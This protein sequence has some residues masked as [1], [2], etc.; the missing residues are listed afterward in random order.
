MDPDDLAPCI[1]RPSG[2]MLLTIQD[3]PV[4]V[5]HKEWFQPP[6][7]MQCWDMFVNENIGLMFPQIIDDVTKWKH[8]QRYWPFARGI[9]Q[10][11]VDYPHKGQRRGALMFSLICT[12]TNSKQSRH[13]WFK[14]SLRSLWHDCSV[15][16]TMI[17]YINLG[18]L[19]I[20]TNLRFINGLEH[21]FINTKHL[22]IYTPRK[23]LTYH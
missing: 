10:S 23:V 13:R 8:F 4:T 22:Y 19:C 3:T 12:C 9:H 7:Q 6:A 15:S 2:D 17:K 21:E 16:S 5:F 1:A 14:T 11:L 18:L 20:I